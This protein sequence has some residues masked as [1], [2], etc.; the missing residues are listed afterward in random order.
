MEFFMKDIQFN[1][2]KQHGLPEFPFQYYYIDANHPQYVMPLHWHGEF[3]IIRVLSGSFE[4]YLDNRL[5]ALNAGECA[6]INCT[7]MHRGIPK[8]CVYEC[9]VFNL[10][11]LYKKSN[12]VIRKYLRPIAHR[13]VSIFETPTKNTKDIINNIFAESS[14]QNDLYELKIHSLLYELFLNFYKENSVI[15]SEK[16]NNQKQFEKIG[17]LLHWIDQNYTEN[18]NLSTLSGISGL[19][20]KYLCRFFKEYTG[21]TP[22]D[23]INNLR[24]E[25][26]CYEM[27]HSGLSVTEA[28]LECGFNS[29][30]YF[31]K[32]FKKYKNVTPTEYKNSK[33]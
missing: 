12:D 25:A 17:E 27:R 15:Y 5:F 31:T 8:E 16:P 30:S 4:L 2:R 7:A 20:Q 11:L 23:Y 3:E 24:I 10:S 6:I 18:I 1:E 9:I 33:G 26:A 21:R 13:N 14:K 19:N 29:I 22:I 28:A 32:A